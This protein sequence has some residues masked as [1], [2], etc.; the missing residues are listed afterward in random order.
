MKPMDHILPSGK[1][2]G[3]PVLGVKNQAA[4]AR[5]DQFV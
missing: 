1:E 4:L 3:R 2:C 5:S